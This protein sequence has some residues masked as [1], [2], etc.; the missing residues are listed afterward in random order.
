MPE[1]DPECNENFVN[2]NCGHLRFL[3]MRF[4]RVRDSRKMIE[5]KKTLIGY[6]RLNKN[7]VENAIFL[8][9]SFCHMC[10]N[11]VAGKI[12]MWYVRMV[13]VIYEVWRT[14]K[15]DIRTIQSMTIVV[16]SAGE[17]ETTAKISTCLD[18]YSLCSGHRL[19]RGQG[20]VLMGKRKPILILLTL[21]PCRKYSFDLALQWPWLSLIVL[22]R[23]K[24]KHNDT[25]CFFNISQV[26]SQLTQF[27]AMAP[28]FY[29]DPRTRLAQSL[30]SYCLPQWGKPCLDRKFAP[31]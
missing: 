16:W 27:K 6:P 28:H 4:L 21:S 17:K 8:K 18:N 12:M 11:I 15:E 31:D 19:E 1:F 20:Q 14:N 24:N 29:K 22:L 13:C 25:F 9:N 2:D 3:V 10:T 30:P 23:Y 26:M 5:T 7:F